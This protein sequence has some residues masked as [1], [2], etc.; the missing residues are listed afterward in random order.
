MNDFLQQLRSGSKRFDRGRKSYDGNH[1]R[2][3]DRNAGRDR[4]QPGHRKNYD[5]G[6][7]HNIKKIMEAFVEG[8]KTL[9]DYAQ[10]QAA[11]TERIAQ[12]LEKLCS[13]LEKRETPAAGTPA[14]NMQTSRDTTPEATASPSG[15]DLADPRIKRRAVARMIQKMR[16]EG[17]G[18]DDIAQHLKA[19]NIPTLSG[20]GEWR[21]Q[22]VS[23]LF[24][25]QV[26]QEQ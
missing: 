14:G 21:A 10:R 13:Q 2:G 19:Q 9:T 16:A 26:G 25:Q 5:Q 6:Q 17:K 11:A 12:T 18:F 1:Y 15:N 22:V 24:N 23:R 3:A 8:Q 4:K 20:R 7:L